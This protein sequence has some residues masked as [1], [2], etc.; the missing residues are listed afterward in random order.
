MKFFNLCLIALAI[1][2]AT[3]CSSSPHKGQSEYVQ[4]IDSK[5]A[6]DKQFAGLYN[7]FEFRGTLLTTEIHQGIHKRM[8]EF[9]DWDETLREEKLQKRLSKAQTETRIFMSFFTPKGKDDNLTTSK[10][11]W[12]LYLHVNGQRYEGKPKKAKLNLSEAIAIFP[13]HNRWTTAYYVDFPVPTASAESSK[14]RYEITGPLGKR[15]VV[16]P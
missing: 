12:K 7:N 16:F 15:D 2:F 8:T 13:Y 11:I 5:T 1:V 6:G 3:G 10:T 4:L 14:A 9:Y